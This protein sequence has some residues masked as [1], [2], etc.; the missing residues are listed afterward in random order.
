MSRRHTDSS[1]L[2]SAALVK[3]HRTA[4]S[5]IVFPD[6]T[7]IRLLP[8]E[9]VEPAKL[10]VAEKREI[11]VETERALRAVVRE[12]YAARFRETAAQRIEEALPERERESLARALRAVGKRAAAISTSSKLSST[13]VKA[14][15]VASATLNGRAA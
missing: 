15:P 11:F 1:K 5:E 10:K 9:Q 7:I 6:G 14:K 4:Q 8:G 12:V 2:I 13:P 3:A